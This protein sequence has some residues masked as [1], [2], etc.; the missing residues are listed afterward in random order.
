MRNLVVIQ[1]K[2][3]NKRINC[4]DKIITRDREGRMKKS[5]IGRTV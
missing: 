2:S 5:Q 1:T 3:T 4:N